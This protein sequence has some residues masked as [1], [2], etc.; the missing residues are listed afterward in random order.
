[1]ERAATKLLVILTLFLVV[2]ACNV[3]GGRR[4]KQSHEKVDQPQ[5]YFGGF[6]GTGAVIPTP[7]GPT[8][9][10]GPSGF[11]SFPGVGCVRVQPQQPTLPGGAIGS[12]P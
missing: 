3:E 9:A 2:L 10:F 5:N 4:L 1:M 11:C 7:F 12:P 6:G 8:I